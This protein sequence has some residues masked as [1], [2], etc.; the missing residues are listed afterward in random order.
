MPGGQL[1]I[2]ALRYHTL[3]TD[4][5]PIRILRSETVYESSRFSVVRDVQAMP[6]GSEFAWESVVY[7]ESV[8][9]VPI[10]AE[11]HV[12]LVRQY[13]PQL[14]RET[15]EVVGGGVDG[16]HTPVEAIHAELI[17]EAGLTARLIPLGTSQL[18]VST[19]RC[20]VHFYLAAIESVGARELEPFEAWTMGSLERVPLEQ[21]VELVLAGEVIDVNSRLAIMLA[22]EHV[23]RHGPASL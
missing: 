22:A 1:L 13:R 3:M 17:E 5:P 18:G 10:D 15:L 2:A 9:A 7:R 20:Q 14:R 21:A 23:R 16:A 11:R 6:D 12:F 19:V 8:H 4:T